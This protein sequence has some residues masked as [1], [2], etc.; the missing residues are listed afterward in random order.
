MV[1]AT[2]KMPAKSWQEAMVVLGANFRR[3]LETEVE[4]ST[5]E[6]FEVAQQYF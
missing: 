1:L 6:T 2:S 4:Q 3:T 5:S